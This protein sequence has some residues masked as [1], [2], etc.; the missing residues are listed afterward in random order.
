METRM[1]DRCEMLNQMT[2]KIKMQNCEQTLGVRQISS[3]CYIEI[4]PYTSII[5][6]DH[7]KGRVH[8]VF[9]CKMLVNNDLLL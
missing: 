6:M 2:A 7:T 3:R 5:D 4:D 1:Q 9:F 8:N